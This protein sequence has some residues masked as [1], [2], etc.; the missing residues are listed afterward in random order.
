VEELEDGDGQVN[1]RNKRGGGAD[2]LKSSPAGE[3]GKGNIGPKGGVMAKGKALAGKAK[4]R[5]EPGERVGRDA[6]EGIAEG[7]SI[8]G[9]G[10]AN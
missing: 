1:E 10:A 9:L 6:E 4:G 2:K 5:A 7:K 3:E 8:S